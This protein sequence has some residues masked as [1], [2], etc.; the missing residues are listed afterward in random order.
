[1]IERF[2][3]NLFNRFCKS[4][5][6]ASTIINMFL[7]YRYKKLY[8]IIKYESI[9]FHSVQHSLINLLNSFSGASTVLGLKYMPYTADKLIMKK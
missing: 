9:N 6:D 4:S 2:T 1:M 5:L 3:R 8:G 7:I